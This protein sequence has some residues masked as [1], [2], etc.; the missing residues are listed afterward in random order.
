MTE[1][2]PPSNGAMMENDR[3]SAALGMVVHAS[4]PGRAVVS[5]LLRDDMMNG[6]D[7]THGGIV[8]ALA[9]TAFAIACNDDHHVTLASGADITFLKPT[10]AGQTL[11]ATAVLRTKS[12]RSGLYDVRV[13]NEHN[14][15]VAEFRGRSRTTNF[16]VPGSVAPLL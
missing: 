6:F 7:V 1:V 16:P 9:D 11:T 14:V 5:M 10:A 12:G 2:L 13:A 8:F 4:E 15:P 3:A